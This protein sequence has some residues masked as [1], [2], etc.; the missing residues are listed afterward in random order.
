MRGR[1]GTQGFD[2]GADRR[3]VDDM[4]A[5]DGQA[6]A[7]RDILGHPARDRDHRV[8]QRIEALLQPAQPAPAGWRTQ[9]MP[10]AEVVV[11]ADHDP[12]R[13]PAQPTCQQRLE[14]AVRRCRQQR[15]GARLVE[16]AG[17]RR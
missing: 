15:L 11:L 13:V 8:G 3:I 7:G 14:V 1:G 12:G 10:L 17:Q 16:V 4:D 5:L 9:R 6:A 2:L